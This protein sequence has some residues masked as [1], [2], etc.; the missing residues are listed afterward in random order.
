M[1]TPH[2]STI[3]I[4]VLGAGPKAAAI[5]TKAYVLDRLGVASISQRIS[6]HWKAPDIARG[7][8]TIQQRWPLRQMAKLVPQP[9]DAVA[10]GLEILNA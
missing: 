10:S 1:T 9:Q 6:K 4:V 7:L 3:D 2:D 8:E 5:T